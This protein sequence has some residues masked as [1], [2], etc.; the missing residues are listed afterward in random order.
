MAVA[1]RTRARKQPADI[2]R[3]AIID[4]AVRVFARMPYRAAGTA[5][6]AREAGIAEPTIYRH[7]ESKRALYLAALERSNSLISGEWRR[8]L[9][10]GG[11]AKAALE[12]I[13]E[14]YYQRV[15]HDADSLRLR[16]RAAAEAEDDEVRTVLRDGYDALVAAVA[17][18]IRRGQE[19]G[20][21]RRDVDPTAAAW[22]YA[23]VG[24][25]LDL[26][27]L[28]GDPTRQPW[29]KEMALTLWHCLQP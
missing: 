26:S 3:E 5:E 29:C 6:I 9:D 13:A 16:H 25:V 28:L 10:I 14:W 22:L 21:V 2:R 8:I 12:A 18:V 24:R 1:A 7:F 11:S 4:A 23:G 15:T 19:T 20:E 17:D 27:A